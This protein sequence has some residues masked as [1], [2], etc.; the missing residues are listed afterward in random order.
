MDPDGRRIGA[1]LPLG[2][3]MVRAVERA[4]ALGLDTLQVFSDNP[5]AWRRRGAPPK[6]LP[7]FRAR[8][9]E[10][11]MGPIAIHAAY[12]VN[13]A[14]SDRA[15]VERSIAVLATE[16]RVAPAFGARFVNAHIGS[17]RGTD[18]A[19]GTAR[20]A[21]GIARVLAEVDD[22]PDA[23]TVVL[24]NSAGSGDGLGAT[25]EEIAD[26][27][28]SI[29]AR[30]VPSSRVAVC[31]DTA[32]LWAAGY[33]IADPIEVDRLVTE[34]DRLIGLDRLAMIHL[35]DSRSEL[36]S[37]MDRHQHIG[38]G[39]IGA[40]GMRAVLVHPHLAGAAYYLETPGMDEGYD[41]VNAARVHDLIAGRPLDELP[42][43]AM[44]VRGSRSRTHPASDEGVL[45]EPATAPTTDPA[46][47]PPE[48]A[49][50]PR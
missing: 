34:F 44:N 46:T 39:S 33:R 2:Q 42:P 45:D 43:E 20:L 40:A 10:L 15:F 35:N 23:A 3:G 31:L 7:A 9:E 29:A 50:T 48:S 47:A 37:R 18:V 12:L 25:L 8:I 27:V 26:I 38:A 41:A 11:G 28:D 14:G 16:L 32:H 24:E 22:G 6:E 49:E 4:H 17:H 21:D 1:H 36:G 5:T 13:L 30:G 19:T